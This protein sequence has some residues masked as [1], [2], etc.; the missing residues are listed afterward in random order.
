MVEQSARVMWRAFPYFEWR[1][2]ARGRAFGRSDAG[3]LQTLAELD[4]AASW[5]QVLWLARLLAARGMPS[6][7]LVYQLESLGRIAARRAR[8]AAERLLAL[9]QQLR[10]AHHAVLSPS[11][12]PECERRCQAGSTGERRRAGAG[13][14]LAA[15]VSDRV[16]GL[17][18]FDEALERWFCQAVPEDQ[19]WAKACAAARAHALAHCGPA[20]GAPP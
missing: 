3:F 18:E 9:A 17:G 13:L 5:Q 2:G 6:L 10:G 8:P 19:A 20:P 16:L 12:F 14:L 7:L 15:A 1:F 11:V 4:F